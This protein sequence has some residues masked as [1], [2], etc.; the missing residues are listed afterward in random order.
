MRQITLSIAA[1]VCCCAWPTMNAQQQPVSQPPASQISSS[2]GIFAYP[3]KGQSAQQQQQDQ[4]TCYAW[5]KQQTGLDPMAGTPATVDT[6]QQQPAGG[7][8]KGAAKGAVAGTLIGAAAGNAGTGA[9]VGAA[10]GGVGGRAGQN[11]AQ[12]QQQQQS[13]A[14]AQQTAAQN[15][16]TFNRAYT[17]CM[18]PKGYNIQ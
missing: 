15:K 11:Q 2:L 8:V 1:L 17:A 9:A 4:N 12:A 3:T 16:A 10:V 13:A 14:N 5:A 7:A 18:Q 6:A